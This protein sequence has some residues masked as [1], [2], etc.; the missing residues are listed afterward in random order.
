MTQLVLNSKTTLISYFNNGLARWKEMPQ[1]TRRRSNTIFSPEDE[2]LLYCATTA[3]S[4][5]PDLQWGKCATPT[6]TRQIVA[7][8]LFLSVLRCLCDSGGFTFFH[9]PSL[10]NLRPYGYLAV[11]A[12][13]V[14]IA[15]SLLHPALPMCAVS[16]S[17]L[18]EIHNFARCLLVPWTFLHWTFL[19]VYAMFF[20]LN[21]CVR[22]VRVFKLPSCYPPICQMLDGV[23]CMIDGDV[24]EQLQLQPKLDKLDAHVMHSGLCT[25]MCRSHRA[26]TIQR[27]QLRFV[28]YSEGASGRF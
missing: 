16:F 21:S 25:S 7:G 13:K 15:M 18:L 1:R 4:W 3:T 9:F 14:P 19:M 10:A 17:F 2:A 6:A 11:G 22:H 26:W 8:H 24:W 12:S 20:F 28:L 5:L 27:I 23:S